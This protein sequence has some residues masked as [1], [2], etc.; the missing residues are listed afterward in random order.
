MEKGEI[1][2]SHILKMTN[3]VGIFQHANFK[4]P[5]LE[6]GYTT[7]DNSRCLI[8]STALE[9]FQQTDDKIKNLSNIYFSFLENA[10]NPNNKRFRNSLTHDGKWINSEG[11]TN[12]AGSEDSH[13]R[14]LWSL[15]FAIAKT[16]DKALKAK[17]EK[18]FNKALEPLNSF[19]SPRAWAYSI[20]GIN[21]Y[22]EEYPESEQ[23]LALA[24]KLAE[25]LLDIYKK[26][27]SENWIWFENILTYANAVLPHA[28]LI[29]GKKTNNKGM[30]EVGLKTLEWLDNVQTDDKNKHFVPIGCKGFWEKGKEKTRYDQQPIEAHEMILACK[31]AYKITNN[32]IWKERAI[33]SLNWYLGENDLKLKLYDA[34][35][36]ACYDGLGHET[37]NN[38]QGAEST[39]S[40]LLSL[41]EMN[42]F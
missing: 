22:L 15:G 21:Y 35:T 6:E 10:F 8:L 17:A 40:A 28:L 9:N 13:A 30:K 4:Q 41:I 2:L 18:L 32:P 16:N 34:E 26:A 27:N 3:D 23:F 7:C 1:N 31:E 39:I 25:K 14:A 11:K 24:E 38:N 36:G 42:E 20:R 37:V 5:N 33:K 12:G 29:I 19:T